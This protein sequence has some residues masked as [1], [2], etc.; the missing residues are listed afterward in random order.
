M[1]PLSPTLPPSWWLSDRKD[2][3][4]EYKHLLSWLDLLEDSISRSREKSRQLG[5]M[6]V[7]VYCESSRL[8]WWI[9]IYSYTSV[10]IR[11][12]I[13]WMEG[14]S[15]LSWHYYGSKGASHKGHHFRFQS[16]QMK[17]HAML[18][19]RCWC[20]TNTEWC[21]KKLMNSW[22]HD[23]WTDPSDS[24]CGEF[25]S[26]FGHWT[27]YTLWAAHKLFVSTQYNWHPVPDTKY[28]LVISKV[29][30]LNA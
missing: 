20:Q 24:E 1:P 13:W 27:H 23:L 5:K 19:M 17:D 16:C 21:F 9:F 26:H 30:P 18:S 29:S 14:E 25:K 11:G 2:N 3:L 6:C 7:A 8:L 15:V 22:T 12:R 4:I 10:P 28:Y